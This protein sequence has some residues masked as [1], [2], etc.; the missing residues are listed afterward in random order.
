MQIPPLIPTLQRAEA[1]SEAEFRRLIH[2][3]DRTLRD[4]ARQVAAGEMLPS[5]WSG[6][7]LTALSEAH[8][9]AGFHGRQRA[10]DL[11]AFDVD[12]TRFGNLAAQEEME[13]LQSFE[14]DLMGDRYRGE[15]GTLDAAQVARRAEHYLGAL[16]GTANEAM[17]LVAS[18]P[19]W[20]ILG[21]P[22]SGPSGHCDMCPELAA[23]S[24]YAP[25]SLPTY[26]RAN[27]TPCLQNCYCRIQTESGLVG[28]TP[29]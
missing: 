12:D 3:T 24:P 17:V 15:D 28:F 14:W 4:L 13:F 26:P 22:E 16:Y 7:M 25:G 23:N 27:R 29:G 9:R 20:W 8:A 2:A 10:G 1:G 5:E 21:E 11:A 6:R 19:V 18:E